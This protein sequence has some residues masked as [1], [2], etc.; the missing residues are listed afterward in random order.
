[1]QHISRLALS[2]VFF[3]NA[4]VIAQ[5]G[6]EPKQNQPRLDQY[7]DPLPDGALQRLGTVRFRGGGGPGVIFLPDGKTLFTGYEANF[8]RFWDIATGRPLRTIR[9][10]EKYYTCRAVSPDGKLLAIGDFEGIRLL[11]MASGK[12]IRKIST[13]M[14]SALAFTPDGKGL[15][16]GDGNVG[17]K[18]TGVH[19]WDVATGTERHR[20]LCHKQEVAFVAA[21][22]DGKTLISA[23]RW[24]HKIHFADLTTGKEVRWLQESEFEDHAYAI[25]PDGRYLA[26]G[27]TLQLRFLN[28][29]HRNWFPAL[30]LIDIATGQ[31]VRQLEGH[32]DSV[33]SVAFSPDGKTLAGSSFRKTIRFWE[34]ATG[35]E[36]GTIENAG[37]NLQYAPDGKTLL[38]AAG[39]IDFW[40]VD[41]RKRMRPLPEGHAFAAGGVA[42]APNGKTIVSSDHRVI[43][44]WDAGTGNPLR[45]LSEPEPHALMRG[46]HFLPDGKTFITGGTDSLLRF[47]NA[48]TGDEVRR[49]A[50]HDPARNEKLQQVLTLGVSGDGKTVSAV[51]TGFEDVFPQPIRFQAWDTASGERRIYRADETYHVFG[52]AFAHDGK[53]AAMRAAKGIA[54]I[55]VASGQ[56]LKFIAAPDSKILDNPF[57]FSPDGKMLAVSGYRQREG[58]KY[59]ARDDFAIH[60]YDT[61]TGKQRW[62]SP[63]GERSAL[64]F[65]PDGKTLAVADDKGLHFLD[66][67][68]GKDL[69]RH[70]PVDAKVLTLAFA[71]DGQRIASGMNDGTILIWDARPKQTP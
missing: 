34:V 59:L 35:K 57:A 45:R 28:P 41:T 36:T 6:P 40:D 43:W 25:S 66:T 56:Q 8:V 50:L 17:A 12:E 11:D 44:L 53:T 69:L 5:E 68:T 14:V 67:A 47:W 63:T 52:Q 30:R 61:Q 27:G 26:V 1:M 62:E 15:L 54:I 31:T 51:T 55:D 9:V 22:P 4:C 58:G 18:E 38:V 42:F 19:V 13:P 10:A 33:D 29:G 70:R 39:V 21:T 46:P 37:G 60:L 2:S 48:D 49:I 16:S 7:G 65:A 24:D 71:P 3:F 64:A 20:L 32:D 23:S